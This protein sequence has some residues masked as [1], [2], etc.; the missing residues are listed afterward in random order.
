MKGREEGR[1]EE[2][3]KKERCS[4]MVNNSEKIKGIF[5]G[6]VWM[7]TRWPTASKLAPNDPCLLF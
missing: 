3:R 4:R 1:K 2:R 5:C 7:L 6:L